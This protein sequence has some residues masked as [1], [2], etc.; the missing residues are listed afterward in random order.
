MSEQLVIDMTEMNNLVEKIKNHETKELAI[1]V[2]KSHLNLLEALHKA[3]QQQA[4]TIQL[5]KQQQEM[6]DRLTAL[7]KKG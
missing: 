5:M 6:I 1:A 7:V 3:L 2:R 4:D